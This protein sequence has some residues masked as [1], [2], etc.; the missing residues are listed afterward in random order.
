MKIESSKQVGTKH[1]LA[2]LELLSEPKIFTYSISLIQVE[3]EFGGGRG[4]RR[5]SFGRVDQIYLNNFL[6]KFI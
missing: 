5:P 3:Q 2:F 1:T 4:F 6:F